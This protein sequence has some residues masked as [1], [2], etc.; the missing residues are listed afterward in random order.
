MKTVIFH[1]AL[2]CGSQ[3]AQYC[4]V[5]SLYLR[6]VKKLRE[7]EAHIL[8]KIDEGNR[9]VTLLFQLSI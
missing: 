5:T 6:E 3:P 1:V 8:G 4:S 9:Q 7:R 2:T